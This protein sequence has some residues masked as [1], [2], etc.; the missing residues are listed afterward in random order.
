MFLKVLV[1]LYF[2]F[3]SLKL[4][5]KG[6]NTPTGCFREAMFSKSNHP[7]L[8]TQR[9]NAS[10]KLMSLTTQHWTYLHMFRIAALTV[11]LLSLKHF[12]QDKVAKDIGFKHLL[13]PIR[14][15]LVILCQQSF[16]CGEHMNHV[17]ETTEDN[18]M[19]F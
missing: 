18:G 10:H 8:N 1:C 14:S 17:S 3:C 4:T 6:K 19:T 11:G 16:S 13:E 12:Y 2:T 7:H 9:C 5:S 15:K